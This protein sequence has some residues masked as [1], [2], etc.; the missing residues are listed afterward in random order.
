MKHLALGIMGE[1]KAARLLAGK[2]WR[3]VT[4]NW[5]PR[6]AERGLELDIVAMHA[7]SLVFVEVKT[8]RVPHGD[9]EEKRHAGQ[10]GGRKTSPVNGESARPLIVPPRAALTP[11]KQKKLVRAAGHYL[12]VHG[13]WSRPCRFDLVCVEEFP[14]GQS[15]LEHHSDVIE[16]RQIVGGGDAAWQPW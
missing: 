5:R 2:G 3:I 13:L 16:L 6:G 11:A 8:R 1:E 12:T 4:R 10:E 15:R 9:V 14:D 7:D